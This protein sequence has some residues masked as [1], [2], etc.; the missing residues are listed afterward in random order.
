M[1]LVGLLACDK[2]C[3]RLARLHSNHLSS[4]LACEKFPWGSCGTEANYSVYF[5]RLPVYAK[6]KRKMD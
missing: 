6:E 3:D 1:A 5:S 4:V 2:A